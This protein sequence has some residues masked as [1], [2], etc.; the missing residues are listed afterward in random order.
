MEEIAATEGV[1]QSQSYQDLFLNHDTD[2]NGKINGVEF[3]NLLSGI[4]GGF[5]SSL[6]PN[7]TSQ[8]GEYYSEDLNGDGILSADEDLGLDGKA[9]TDD[10]GEGNGVIDI[11]NRSEPQWFTEDVNGDGI[12][13]EEEDFGLDGLPD[14]GDF[15]EGNGKLD[16]VNEPLQQ[17]QG[18]SFLEGIAKLAAPFLFSHLDQNQDGELDSVEMGSILGGISSGE[19]GSEE[20]SAEA[21]ASNGLAAS[22]LANLL[23]ATVIQNQN[24]TKDVTLNLIT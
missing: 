14:T 7:Q 1:S 10:F 20:T 15:G 16:F 17:N 4:L 6:Q 23:G 3:S 8:F 11:A 13:G 21:T 2:K 24:H 12:L 19:E 18:P 5:K 22:P 9:D